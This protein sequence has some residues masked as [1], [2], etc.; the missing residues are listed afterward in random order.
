M[1]ITTDT[2]YQP[3]FMYYFPSLILCGKG[4]PTQLYFESTCIEVTFYFVYC[5]VKPT[6]VL[7]IRWSKRNKFGISFHIFST[8]MYI[9]THHE[10]ILGKTALM[11]GNNMLRNKKKFSQNYPCYPFK[12]EALQL[13]KGCHLI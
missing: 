1:K 13:C 5:F 11:R 12:S 8:K 2:F 4:N 7:M 3:D 9:V 10:N 6:I